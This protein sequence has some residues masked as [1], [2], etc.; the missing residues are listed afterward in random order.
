VKPIEHRKLVAYLRRGGCEHVRT[1]SSHEWWTCP[2]GCGTV[3]VRDRHVSLGVLR[4][5]ERNL[6]PCLGYG[7]L[8]EVQ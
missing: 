6:R 4:Q 3:V 8:K 5:I 2:G 7:W 1:Q